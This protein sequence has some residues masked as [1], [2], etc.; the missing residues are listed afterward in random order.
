MIINK[1]NNLE[2]LNNGDYKWK[3]NM[4]TTEDLIIELDDRLVVEGAVKVGGK[5]TGL[6]LWK[7]P[8]EEEKYITCEELRN[9]EIAYGKLNL[10]PKT[11]K[12]EEVIEEEDK[13]IEYIDEWSS[14]VEDNQFILKNK[15][16]ELIDE[17]N[18]LKGGKNE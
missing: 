9:G 16:Q 13:K 3:G 10:I 4:E 8:S 12:K 17:V 5:F 7:N 1:E 18:A 11:E 2:R 6:C 14:D 15:I